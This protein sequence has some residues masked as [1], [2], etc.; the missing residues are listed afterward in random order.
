MARGLGSSSMSAQKKREIQSKGGAA[1]PQN[2][3]KNRELASRA[4]K[5]G[6]SH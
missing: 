1:S 2:F 4:G 5:I 6:G 3:K